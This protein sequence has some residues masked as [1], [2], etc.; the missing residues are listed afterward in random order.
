[1]IYLFG[2]IILY[3]IIIFSFFL[4]WGKLNYT[5]DE[6]FTPSVSVVIALRNEEHQVNRLLNNLRN[7]DYPDDLVQYILVN[8]HSTDNTFN[9][10]LDNKSVNFKIINMHEGHFG[11]KQAIAK[12]V[13]IA[14]GDIIVTSDAD[15]SFN[16]NWIK[17]MVS[18]YHNNNVKLVAGPVVFQNQSGIFHLFQNLEFLSLIGSGAGAIGQKKAIFCNAANMSFKKNVFLELNKYSSEIAS[19]DDVFLLHKIKAKYPNGIVFAKN[20]EAIVETIGA[21]NIFQFFNQRIRWTAKS[22]SYSDVDALLVSIIVFATNFFGVF[23]IILSIIDISFL[24]YL[25]LYFSIKSI[26]DLLLLSK[27]LNFFDRKY[28][29]KWVL[30]F[31]ILYSIYIVF[32]VVYSFI[33]SFEWKG[34]K[35][36]K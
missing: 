16:K 34:R 14:D 13:S 33:F 23:F 10:L 18:Y 35:Y 17:K 30:P 28:L 3:I 31:Q 29:I 4:G 2:F 5:T 6:S 8:D 36:S 20:K 11:K 7:L 32:I 24:S 15:C 19:G 21:K 9:L 1:M 12:G 22:T 27:V 26:L 25:I